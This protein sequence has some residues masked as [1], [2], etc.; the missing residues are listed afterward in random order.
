MKKTNITT[1]IFLLITLTLTYNVSAQCDK[2][3]DFATFSTHSETFSGDA[4]T[5]HITS[6]G[7]ISTN[8]CRIIGSTNG[9]G[10]TASSY[11]VLQ[12]DEKGLGLNGYAS[13]PGS[14]VSPLLP[15]G[16]KSISFNYATRHSSVTRNVR[17]YITRENGDEILWEGTKDIVSAKATTK[18]EYSIE[19]IN[20]TGNFILHIVNTSGKSG[21][22][23]GDDIIIWN[24]CI[25][26]YAPVVASLPEF[27]VDGTKKTEDMYWA[28][29]TVG[30]DVITTDE[31]VKIH[32]TTDGT[33]PTAASPVYS[34]PLELMAT[35]R[36]K[37]IA[38]LDDKQGL[39]ADTL[40]SIAGPQSADLSYDESFAGSLG[41]WYSYSAAGDQVWSA[42]EEDELTFAGISGADASGTSFYTNEDWLISPAFTA[43]TGH[44][45]AFSFASAKLYDGNNLTLKYS[46]DYLG[47]GN[48]TV[49]TWTDI[50]ASALWSTEGDGEWVA[51]GEVVVDTVLPVRFAFVYTS[52]T[53][54]AADWLVS[55]VHVS[56][57]DV[58]APSTP[59]ELAAISTETEIA[60]TWEASTDNVAVA[61]YIL[62][63]NGDSIDTVTELTYT[64]SNL[65]TDTEYTL[66]VE[67][68]DDAGNRSPKASLT[69]NTSKPTSIPVPD[70][71]QTA[72]YP[73]P[74]ADYIII[75]ATANEEIVIYDLSGKALLAANVKPGNNRIDASALPKGVYLLKAGT[76]IVKIVK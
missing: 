55:N 8:A 15:Y 11:K 13:T 10:S 19:N 38:I 5:Q 29:V 68:F 73:N 3:D 47:V 30:I 37:A 22:G 72:V 4:N 36:V 28:P 25:S 63:L 75:D 62:Y 40:I 70:E 20:V 57:F 18:Y 74:F 51:S 33:D 24:I 59:T 41:N 32:Y 7:W 58:A 66:E 60:L 46:T 43:A 56:E 23:Y 14:I 50:S 67:A 39:I 65:T 9:T 69:Q 49:A 34:E 52:T 21:S 16:C 44:N 12:A 1:I 71:N 26:N 64:F 27:T 6:A 35:S 48:P 61:G 17:F 45:I 54:D 31:G 42:A 76:Q 53:N 2:R